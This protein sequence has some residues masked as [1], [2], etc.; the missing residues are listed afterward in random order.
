[1]HDNPQH[2]ADILWGADAIAAEIR[3]D[4]SAT[5]HLLSAGALPAKKVGG[6]WVASRAKLREFLLGEVAA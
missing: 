1:M 3:R 2:D 5:F 4:R 6:R